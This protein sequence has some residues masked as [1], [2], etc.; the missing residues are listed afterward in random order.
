MKINAI[1]IKKFAI[2]KKCNQNIHFN[3][4][5]DTTSLGNDPIKNKN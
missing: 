3:Q 1:C 2:Y 5:V 4:G